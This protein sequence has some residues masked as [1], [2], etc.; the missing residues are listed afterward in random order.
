MLN[1]LM[2]DLAGFCVGVYWMDR[3]CHCFSIIGVCFC[4]KGAE[5]TGVG[6]GGSG[7]GGCWTRAGALRM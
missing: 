4:G 1:G 2:L 3:S 6:C 7:G 5:S